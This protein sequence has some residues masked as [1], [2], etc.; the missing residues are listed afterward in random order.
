LE[1][2]IKRTISTDRLSYD[3]PSLGYSPDAPFRV[4]RPTR[5]IQKVTPDVIGRIRETTTDLNDGIIGF[6]GKNYILNSMLDLNNAVSY[7]GDMLI[8]A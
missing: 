2:L 1:S 5:I 4:F 7:V 8:Y 3:V 6:L